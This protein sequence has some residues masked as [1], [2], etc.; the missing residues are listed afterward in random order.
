MRLRYI[1]LAGFKSFADVVKVEVSGNLTGV[2]GPNGCGKSNII[3]AVRWVLGE[4]SINKLRG[5]EMTD[6]IF[7]GSQTRRPSGRSSVELFF[8]ND[9]QDFG[10]V[11]SQFTELSIKRELI[12]SSGQSIYSINGK[13][14][15]LKDIQK[16]FMGTG[17]GA[18]A[19]YAIIGQ[20]DIS[21]I[22]ES[23]PEDMRNRLEEAAGVSFYK[24]RRQETQ[25]SLESSQNN[26][27]RI[28][29][30]L[31]ELGQS[32][33]VLT[34]Q[35]EIAQKFTSY[36]DEMQEKQL[37]SW[38]LQYRKAYDELEKLESELDELNEIL[39]SRE[40]EVEGKKSE[41]AALRAVRAKAADAL[42]ELQGRQRTLEGKINSLQREIDMISTRRSFL[43]SDIN[44]RTLEKKRADEEISQMENEKSGLNESIGALTQKEDSLKVQFRQ[45]KDRVTAAEKVCQKIRNEVDGAYRDLR[46]KEKL[47]AECIFFIQADQKTLQEAQ[48]RKERLEKEQIS[49]PEPR[50]ADLATLETDIQTLES[51]LSEQRISI[52]EQ[53]GRLSASREKEALIENQYRECSARQQAISVNLSSLIQQQNRYQAAEGVEDWLRKKNIASQGTLSDEIQVKKGWEAAVESV[54]SERLSAHQVSSEALSIIAGEQTTKSAVFYVAGKESSPKNSANN[55][56]PLTALLKDKEERS[57]QLCRWLANFYIAENATSAFDQ[58]DKLPSGASFVLKDGTI[59]GQGV[60]KKF[61]TSSSESSV[62]ARKAHISELQTQSG[63]LTE[64]LEQLQRTLSEQKKVRSTKEEKLKNLIREQRQFEERLN[65]LRIRFSTLQEKNKSLVAQ[66]E[67][68][69]RELGE[70]VQKIQKLN[71]RLT[72]NSADRQEMDQEQKFLRDDLERVKTES[73]SK[74]RELEAERNAQRTLGFEI[75]K[76]NLQL[77]HAREEE[78]RTEQRISKYKETLQRLT[79]S[80]QKNSEE[81]AHLDDAPLLLQLEKENS[82]KEAILAQISVAITELEKSQVAENEADRIRLEKEQSLDPIRKRINLIQQKLGATR[83]N[84]ERFGELLDQNRADYGFLWEVIH[85]KSFNL[86]VLKQ[87]ISSLDESIKALGPVNLAAMQELTEKKERFDALTRQSEDVIKAIKTLKDAIKTIDIETKQRLEATYNAVNLNFAEMFIKLFGGGS[88]KLEKNEEDILQTGFVVKAQPPGKRNSTISSLSGGEKALTAIAFVLSIFKLNPAPFCLLDEVDA[89]LDEANQ[90]RFASLIKEMSETTQFLLITHKR[91]TMEHL[92]RIIGVTMKEAGVS[93]VVGVDMAK[94]LSYA[95]RSGTSR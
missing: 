10:G 24:Q 26:L 58:L 83:A 76:L 62:L 35:A 50:K 9:T 72:S 77:A 87:E 5:M 34:K 79:S 13:S 74:V 11:W 38:F 45:Q 57:S 93:Q 3:D 32:V 46:A 94:A 8:D 29:D 84:K 92:V 85:Q 61:G 49:I 95:N 88:A 66:K 15:R 18:S 17:L 56:V 23:R 19:P 1:K 41:Y 81:L 63:Q 55:L 59:I 52:K 27:E 53:E 86:A 70:Q 36:S 71:E 16:I 28:Q 54:L 60:V 42:F 69:Q 43:S 67:R 39:A 37:I 6:V 82:Q 68:I 25:N 48:S 20:G 14:V 75:D 30:I 22:V 44:E 91:V 2:V 90:D 31:R 33:T 64:K 51:M 65:D 89:P 7:N 21:E 80:I 47:L 4:R 78:K 12:R 73:A 40:A